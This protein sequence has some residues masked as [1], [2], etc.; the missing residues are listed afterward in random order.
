MYSDKGI[1]FSYDHIIPEG[2]RNGALIESSNL[3]I[4]ES[5]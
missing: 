5:N 4:K 1:I 2:S 3:K